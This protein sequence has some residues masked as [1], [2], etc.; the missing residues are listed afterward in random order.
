M[1]ITLIKQKTLS[2]KL[3]YFYKINVKRNALNLKKHSSQSQIF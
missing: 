3:N 2:L 1:P